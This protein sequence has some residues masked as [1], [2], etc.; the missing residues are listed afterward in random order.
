LIVSEHILSPNNDSIKGSLQYSETRLHA[1]KIPAVVIATLLLVCS[2]F[3]LGVLFFS[4]GHVVPV[5]PNSLGGMAA[6]IGPISEIETFSRLPSRKLHTNSRTERSNPRSR[7]PKLKANKAVGSGSSERLQQKKQLKSSKKETESK[8][9]YLFT[10]H[11]WVRTLAIVLCLWMIVAL[12]I[13][14]KKSDRSDGIMD[15]TSGVGTQLWAT[16][17]PALALTGLAVL[18]SS[19]YTNIALLAPYHALTTK[20]EATANR[21]IATQYAGSTSLF[22]MLPSMRQDQVSICVSVFAAIVH[23][24]N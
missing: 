9:R 1:V 2:G 5:N 12:E 22:A 15:A 4:P 24:D 17:R 11:A 3:T 8:N 13:L 20:T 23:A 19:I 6:I 10:L 14:Q 16:V 21:S 7:L 18:Y